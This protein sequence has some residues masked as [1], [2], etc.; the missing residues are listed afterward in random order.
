M[1]NVREV[2]KKKPGAGMMSA[3]L[4]L[5]A[6]G[7]LLVVAVF[8]SGGAPTLL[9]W[10]LLVVGVILAAIGFTRRAQLGR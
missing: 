10:V 7:L 8:S 9:V 6:I 5:G 2:T 3:G 1:T 4:L